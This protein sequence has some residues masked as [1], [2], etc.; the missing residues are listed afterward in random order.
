MIPM[1]TLMNEAS[2]MVAPDV[3]VPYF[4]RPH[5]LTNHADL[6]IQ[7]AKFC[8]LKVRGAINAL[9][10]TIP[11]QS[12]PEYVTDPQEADEWRERD[13]SRR[14]MSFIPTAEKQMAYTF[15]Q[16][17][18]K[19]ADGTMGP[20]L[21]RALDA[22]NALLDR[23]CETNVSDQLPIHKKTF[24]VIDEAIVKKL[25]QD[26]LINIAS[27]EL[28]INEAIT[29][30]RCFEGR[31]DIDHHCYSERDIATEYQNVDWRTLSPYRPV[32]MP[33]LMPKTMLSN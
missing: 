12:A 24:L 26:P 27:A 28:L 21:R 17:V 33:T 1:G 11:I 3:V 23:W 2:W 15:A 19:M 10:R 8:V 13:H 32:H 14:T 20:D 31:I 16:P 9:R 7:R 4:A 22:W 25:Y 5:D 18:F 29:A 6:A 30:T